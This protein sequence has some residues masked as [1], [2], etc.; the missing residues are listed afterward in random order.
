MYKNVCCSGRILVCM[1]AR[2]YRDGMTS[3]SYFVLSNLGLHLDSRSMRARKK[4][5]PGE[6][7]TNS[8]SVQRRFWLFLPFLLS[9]EMNTNTNKPQQKGRRS[10]LSHAQFLVSFL[11]SR[12][13]FFVGKEKRK[14]VLTRS[15]SRL[16]PNFVFSG[17]CVCTRI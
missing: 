6:K 8:N 15:S 4:N 1:N 13:P 12:S 9:L 5:I 14:K 16:Y 2:R 7:C 10:S 3:K 17:V 11:L